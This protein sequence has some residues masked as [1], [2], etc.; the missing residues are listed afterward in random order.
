[1]KY[2]AI[3]E[4]LKKSAPSEFAPEGTPKNELKLVVEGDSFHWIKK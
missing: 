4:D 2:S 1:M 3:I